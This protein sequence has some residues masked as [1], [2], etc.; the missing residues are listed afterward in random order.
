MKIEHWLR[1]G[2]W[3]LGP[4]DSRDLALVVVL[5]LK[6]ILRKEVVMAKKAFDA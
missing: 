6:R 2:F 4:C 5:G 1:S 3:G